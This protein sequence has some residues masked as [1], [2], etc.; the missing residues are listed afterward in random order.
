MT[1]LLTILTGFL[2]PGLVTGLTQVLFPAQANA[3]LL[4]KN[5]HVIGGPPLKIYSIF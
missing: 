5:G 3:S 1:L 2:Y 4:E